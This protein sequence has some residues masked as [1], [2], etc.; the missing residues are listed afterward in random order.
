MAAAKRS[1]PVP[2]P[3]LETRLAMYRTMVECRR[4]EVRAQEL[5]FEGLVRG[6]THLGVGQEAV[7]AGF[8]AAMRADDYTFA[9]YRGHNHALARGTSMAGLYGELFGRAGGLMGGKGGS[10]HITSAAQYMM[11]SYAIVGAHLPIALG[12]AW[13][14]QYRESG[15]VSICF[16]GDGTTNI[17]AFHEALNMAAVWKAPVVFVCENNQYMEYTP[18]GAVTAVARPAADRAAAYGLEAIVVDGNDADAVYDVAARTIS[19]ARAGDGPSLVEALTYRHGGHS[20]A[21]PGKYRPDDEVEAWK[22]RDPVPGY[23]ARLVEAGIDSRTLDAIEA[24]VTAAVDAAEADARAQP[25]PTVDV[26]ET[27]V[28]ADGGSAWRN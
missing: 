15:Q 1:A 20:R 8:G 27:Q 28:W 3:A 4:F 16:F 9:T 7:A 6:T 23:R 19:R 17:G 11:G 24:E 5:F 2:V 18:I 13:S 21:D 25:E 12:A 26:I 22:A 14:A 10:M